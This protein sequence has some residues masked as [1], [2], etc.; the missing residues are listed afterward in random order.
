MSNQLGLDTDPQWRV[1][2]RC[3]NGNCVE[4]AYLSENTV[5]LRD[6]KN[7]NSPVLKFTATE[8][9]AFLGRVMETR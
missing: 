6:N 7:P 5:G 3:N 1:S 2:S 4:V 9:S 8:W